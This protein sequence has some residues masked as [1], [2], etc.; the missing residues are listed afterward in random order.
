VPA[1]SS[2]SF[3]AL[4]APPLYIETKKTLLFVLYTPSNSYSNNFCQL[5]SLVFITGSRLIS[6]VTCLSLKDHVR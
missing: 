2:L 5:L 4:I 1:K 6:Y 3:L